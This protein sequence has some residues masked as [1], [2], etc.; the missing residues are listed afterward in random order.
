METD[1]GRLFGL[2]FRSSIDG[3]FGRS[4]NCWRGYQAIYTIE[5][6]S[7]FVSDIIN[8]HSIKNFDKETSKKYLKE[9][10]GE[11]VQNDKVF[12]DWFSG[13]ISF[14]TKFDDNKILRWDGVF[15][16]VFL[17]ETVVK[18]D[19]GNVLEVSDQQNYDDLKNGI[20]RLERDSISNIIFDK[21]KSYKWTN[22]DKFDCS[23][24]YTIVIGVKGKITEVMM[25][26]YQT[27]ESIREFW[28][29]KR[30]YNY[31]I[32]SIKKSL[33]NMQFDILKKKGIPIEEIVFVEIWFNEDGSIENWTN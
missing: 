2:S 29:T 5:N 9:V 25:T 15:E 24:L 8:C 1:D 10:F 16:R 6:D 17:N 19:C 31:C 13:V 7:L 27:K 33:S 26:E 11:K 4:F 23:E 28:D 18:I 3:G 32:K 30:E 21:I 20:D 12:I 14:P 22:L